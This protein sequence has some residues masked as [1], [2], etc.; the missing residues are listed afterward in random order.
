VLLVEQLG[1]HEEVPE[2]C[3]ALLSL[4]GACPDMLSH[5]A[6]RARNIGVLLAA[7]HEPK[8]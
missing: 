5:S 2:G 6:V 1:G 3:C 4:C 8:V 7:C